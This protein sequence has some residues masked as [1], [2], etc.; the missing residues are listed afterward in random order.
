VTAKRTLREIKAQAE[1]MAQAMSQ[2]QQEPDVHTL[3]IRLLSAVVQAES[4]KRLPQWRQASVQGFCEGLAIGRGITQGVKVEPPAVAEEPPAAV[5]EEKPAP[6]V[7]L[8]PPP[9]PVVAT[10]D[11]ARM[12]RLQ[13]E[14][15]Q[16]LAKVQGGGQP[17]TP[18]TAPAPAPA[19]TTQRPHASRGR[20]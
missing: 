20:R 4:Y 10:A 11:L 1:L 7:E 18:S 2:A 5:I 13:V 17:L 6:V 14:L 15:A 9:A 16:L 19:N 3:K 12:E 8:P